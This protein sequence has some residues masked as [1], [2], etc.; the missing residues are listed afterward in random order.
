M[1]L[2]KSQLSFELLATAVVLVVEIRIGVGKMV[3]PAGFNV[4][5]IA[6]GV[7]VHAL[8]GAGDGSTD[9]A[10]GDGGFVTITLCVIGSGRKYWCVNVSVALKVLCIS[11]RGMF[12]SMKTYK[13]SLGCLSFL[14]LPDTFIPLLSYQPRG[15]K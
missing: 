6:G 14:M 1:T 11:W 12:A 2:S 9:G 4:R 7:F 10:F 5:R 8:K 15:Y 13:R 3:V